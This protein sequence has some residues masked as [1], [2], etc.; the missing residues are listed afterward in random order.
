MRA[1]PKRKSKVARDR[2]GHIKTD[3]YVKVLEHAAAEQEHCR[4]PV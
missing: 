1:R 2:I 3:G 4:V